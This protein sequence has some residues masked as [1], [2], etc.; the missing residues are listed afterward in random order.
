MV[1]FVAKIDWR[2]IDFTPLFKL[3]QIS[4]GSLAKRIPQSLHVITHW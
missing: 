3:V 4:G 1:V 2:L